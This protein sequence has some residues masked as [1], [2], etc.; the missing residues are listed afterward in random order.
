M[1]V[2]GVRVFVYTP[3]LTRLIINPPTQIDADRDA[4]FC[5]SCFVSVKNKKLPKICLASGYDFGNPYKI[6]LQPLTI[7]EI[8]AISVNRLYCKCIKVFPEAKVS[9]LR[10]RSS[11]IVFEQDCIETWNKV[12]PRVTNM[13]DG[14]KIYFYGFKG[15]DEAALLHGLA[16]TNGTVSSSSLMVTNKIYI[17]KNEMK[18]RRV[19]I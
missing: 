7:V 13:S 3:T 15:K 9:G 12:L 5:N 1:C 14:I 4:L 18:K 6:G 19:S 11:C 10:L 17:I 2:S 16:D 8:F